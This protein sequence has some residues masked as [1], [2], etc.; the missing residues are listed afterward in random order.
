MRNW[1]R[2]A[3]AALAALAALV[4]AA[5]AT[6][7]YTTPKLSVSYAP[8]NVTNIVA[9]AAVTDDS[10]ARAAFLVPSGTTLTTTAAPG[11]K[12]GT[13]KAQV[14]A[15]ALGGALLP[16]AGDI[17]VAPSGAVTPAT[18]AQCIQDATPQTT[19]LLV[20]QAAG[21]TLNVPAYL[22]PTSALGPPQIVICVPPPDIPPAMGGATFGAKFLGAELTLTGIISPVAQGAWLSLWT[23][24]NAGV[25]TVNTAATVAAPALIAPGGITLTGRKVK[26]IKRLAGTVIQSGAGVAARV[27]IFAAG[28]TGPLKQVKSIRTKANGTFTYAAAKTSKATRFQARVTVGGRDSAA[29]CTAVASAPIGVP[30]VNG[31]ISGFTARSVTV[32]IR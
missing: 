29:V 30:C 13:V 4:V 10:T 27:S 14:S 20:L 1:T 17:V 6:A 2:I 3:L 26:G 23:P 31:T 28:N 18:Q 21:Q 5:V 8:G 22:L 15:L 11:T 32:R 19:W 24:Y 7:A 25:G 12:V 9:S 16:L